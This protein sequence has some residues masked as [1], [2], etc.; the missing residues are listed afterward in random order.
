[1]CGSFQ[2]H[3]SIISLGGGFGG[4]FTLQHRIVEAGPL[5]TGWDEAV[6]VCDRM[7]CLG[8]AASELCRWDCAKAAQAHLNTC[9]RRRSGDWIGEP[10]GLVGGPLALLSIVGNCRVV[11]TGSVGGVCRKGGHGVYWLPSSRCRLHQPALR[12]DGVDM[13]TTGTALYQVVTARARG[14]TL[15][16]RCIPTVC[17]ATKCVYG[18]LGLGMGN[19]ASIR[20]LPSTLCGSRCARACMKRSLGYRA[21]DHK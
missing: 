2:T 6:A 13:Q 1:M 18:L 17:A 9:D 10:I 4:G 11:F 21:C 14:S 20:S 3:L 16:Q 5:C 8:R 15:M 12:R 7:R 19:N